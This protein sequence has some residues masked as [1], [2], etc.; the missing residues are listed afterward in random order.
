MTD[1]RSESLNRLARFNTT[2]THSYRFTLFGEHTSDSKER[3]QQITNNSGAA[4]IQELVDA[5]NTDFTDH[6][7]I[8]F[9]DIHSIKPSDRDYQ[10]RAIAKMADEF[11][12]SAEFD[13]ACVQADQQDNADCISEHFFQRLLTVFGENWVQNNRGEIQTALQQGNY[14]QL[15]EEKNVAQLTDLMIAVQTKP[16]FHAF[17]TKFNE[18]HDGGEEI[19]VN[20]LVAQACELGRAEVQKSVESLIATTPIAVKIG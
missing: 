8:Q 6:C 1:T 2:E 11:N 10:L 15:L 9:E 17:W 3:Y 4:D 20:T 13:A 12:L 14:A 7:R 18:Y 19:D 16:M 5:F